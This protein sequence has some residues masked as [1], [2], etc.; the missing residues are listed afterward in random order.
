M[1]HGRRNGRAQ[2]PRRS[3]K[4]GLPP[5]TVQTDPNAQPTKVH[6]ICYS[7]DAIE[8]VDIVR[9]S[10]IIGLQQKWPNI[11]VDVAGLGSANVISEIGQTLN[12]HPLAVE[13]SVHVH[14][15]AKADDYGDHLFIV[16]R[17]S[18]PGE[19]HITE[20]CSMFLRA[21]ILVRGRRRRLRRL[22]IELSRRWR[23]ESTTPDGHGVDGR[24]A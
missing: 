11:W 18:N 3:A 13:D 1:A 15:R 14:Q 8:E 20:Q 5:G 24:A 21:G 2:K 17:M 22:P 10:Q 7:A 9:P 19:K 23:P 6:A 16:A 4:V 12:L